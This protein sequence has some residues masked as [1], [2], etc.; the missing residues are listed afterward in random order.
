MGKNRCQQEGRRIPAVS[1]PS[2]TP[3]PPL[4]H[5]TARVPSNSYRRCSV[6]LMITDK[7]YL[8][9]ALQSARPLPAHE[10]PG[11]CLR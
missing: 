11:A 9:C 1:V 8:V 3:A 6:G 4:L 5:H 7:S 10:R 2:I